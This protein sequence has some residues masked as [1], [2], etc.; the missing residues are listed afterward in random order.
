[1][2]AIS[3]TVSLPALIRSGSSR[4]RQR[5]RPNSEHPVLR[6][7]HHLHARWNMVR[8]QSWHANAQV[9]IEAIAQFE[10]RASHNAFALGCIRRL[11]W[12]RV[13]EFDRGLDRVLI[14]AL[15]MLPGPLIFDIAHSFA[16][17]RSCW[18]ACLRRC[19]SLTGRTTRHPSSSSRPPSL[20]SSARGTRC[21]AFAPAG[22]SITA[23]S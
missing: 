2:P 6:L 21:A 16:P 3:V 14:V 9:H 20:L 15:V 5:I 22:A 17:L 11:R 7:Q 12:K 13:S 4:P 1:M 19:Y 23:R 8:N 10:C 18:A